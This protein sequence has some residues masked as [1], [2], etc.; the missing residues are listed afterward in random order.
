MYAAD[1]AGTPY[2]G[3]GR[4]L[5][6]GTS[7]N[8]LDTSVFKNTK[9]TERLTLRLEVDANNILNRSYYGAPDPDMADGIS[10]LNNVNFIGASGGGGIIN[11]GTGVRNLTFGGKFL[12]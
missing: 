4:N 9:L 2:P 6:R 12:F 7:Y 11:T 8:N 5:L 1:I 3:S 10:S